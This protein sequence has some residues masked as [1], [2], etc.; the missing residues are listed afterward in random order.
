MREDGKNPEQPAAAGIE[1]WIRVALVASLGAN[2][3]L[4][5]FVAARMLGPKQPHL[6]P[7]IVGLNLRGLPRDLP[8]EVREELE[9][10]MRSYRREIRHAYREYRDQQRKINRLLVEER[11]NEPAIA[12]AHEQLRSLNAQIQGPIQRALID[13]M[14]EMDAET[15]RQIIELRTVSRK[16][17]F[18]RPKSVDGA[19]WRFEW[20]D[21]EDGFRLEMDDQDM[22]VEINPELTLEEDP[23]GE[24]DGQ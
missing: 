3:F 9:D 5:G 10:S 24:D 13:A 8:S 6:A 21:D 19:R 11:L 12:E 1:K 14:K 7:E 20:Q 22:R 4:G 2:I 23:D 17:R 16:R 15:R 18:G